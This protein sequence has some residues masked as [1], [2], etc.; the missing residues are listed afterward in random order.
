[1]DNLLPHLETI[2]NA[3]MTRPV[4]LKI[5]SIKEEIKQKPNNPTPS[6]LLR[7]EFLIQSGASS[8]RRLFSSSASSHCK[9]VVGEITQGYYF[10]NRDEISSTQQLKAGNRFGILFILVGLG[11]II[12]FRLTLAS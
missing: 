9:H 11:L 3:Q 8:G 6:R 5:I 10:A 2:F 7:P 4:T 12:L 1:M